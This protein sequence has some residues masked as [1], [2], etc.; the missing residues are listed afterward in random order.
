MRVTYTKHAL[1][2][3]VELKKEK[4]IVTKMKIRQVLKNPTW[5]GLTREGQD[6]VIGLMDNRHII[7]IVLGKNGGIIKVITF[8]IGRR[9]KYESTL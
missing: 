4:W 5:R 6:T 7:R 8:H 9:G 2:K 3:I 1:E